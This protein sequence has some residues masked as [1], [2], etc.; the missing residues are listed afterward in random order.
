MLEIIAPL[1]FY[2][3][4]LGIFFAFMNEWQWMD[5]LLWPLVIFVM[6]LRRSIE[7]VGNGGRRR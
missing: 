3:Y 4:M 6:M 5:A 7:I 2:A 1:A